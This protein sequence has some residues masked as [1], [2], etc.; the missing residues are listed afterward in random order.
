[1][2][3][4]EVLEIRKLFNKDRCRIERICGCY[5]D[6]HKE[7]KLEMKEAFLSL[8]EE[9]MFKYIELFKRTLSGSI[10]KN[11]LNLEFSL[12]EELG[13]GRQKLLLA[14]RDSALRNEELLESFY[15][16][17]IGTYQFAENYLILLVYGVY[18]IPSR[19]SDGLEMDDASDYM[20]Q[21]ILCSICPV[22]LSKPGLC[23][24]ADSN[25]FIDKLQ[26]WMVQ[27][28]DL[29]FLY[30]AFND[31]N[32]DLHS[33]LYYSRNA[34][35]LHPEIPEDMLGCRLPIPAGGQKETFSTLVEE[36]F[37]EDCGF[38]VA[39]NIHENLNRI[40]EEKKDDPEPTALGKAEVE[41]LL[42]DCGASPE[43]LEHFEKEFDREAGERTS[44]M[45]A[46]VANARRF[47]I[48]TPDI[49]VQVS[50]DRTDLVETRTVDGRECLV[51][52][53]DGEVEVNGIRIRPERTGD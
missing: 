12:E 19:T 13:E 27:K 41:R 42:S 51:I 39:R 48:K 20:Y 25:S 52:R 15:D 9:E 38:E 36:T 7:K 18:D 29:G 31:R 11:L 34:E 24:D 6:G 49:T 53:L 10:G 21:F 37:G 40:L 23:Y 43:Q 35:E 17:I 46:N 2:N 26:D 30:P 16:K 1:M 50:P 8:P 33:L 14:L 3:K 32:T 5:V 45:A 47:E 4:K 22:A 28:P 44:L